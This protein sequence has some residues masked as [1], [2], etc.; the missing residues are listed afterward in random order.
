VA[1]VVFRQLQRPERMNRSL[2]FNEV[3]AARFRRRGVEGGHRI[4]GRQR[5]DPLRLSEIMRI[6]G[7][8]KRSNDRLEARFSLSIQPVT[9]LTLGREVAS[10]IIATHKSQYRKHLIRELPSN[11]RG[12]EP[13][14]VQSRLL[15]VA[16]RKRRQAFAV[17]VTCLSV[18]LVGDNYAG[19]API[20]GG[21]QRS[22]TVPVAFSRVV[23]D[24]KMQPIGPEPNVIIDPDGRG[25]VVGAENGS[26]G[27]A[28]YR[29]GKSPAVISTFA[30]SA[31]E[32][33]AQVA[34]FD[35]NKTP[36]IVV[37]GSNG[38]TFILYNPL[39]GKCATVYQCPWR[40]GV[41]DDDRTH[42]SRD[43]VVGDIDRDGAVDI[44]T[45]A[46]VYFN[47]GRRGRWQFVGQ[48]LI[49]R[50]GDGTT[51]GDFTGNG[52]LDIVAPYRSGTVL[53]RFINPLHHGGDPKRDVWTEQ[54][55]DPHPLFYGNMTTA[56]ADINGDGRKDIV[57]APMHGG[58]G[59][60]WYEAPKNDTGPWRRHVI[61]PTINS[62]HQGS[63]QIGDFSGRGHADIAFAEQ[64]RSP[65][66]RV[67]IF[68]NVAG[69]GTQ[70]RL[71]V[72]SHKGAQ[73][74]EVGMLG[75]G[76][77]LSIVC[78]RAQSP[79]R[80]NELLAWEDSLARAA[81]MVTH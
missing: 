23:V 5:F 36:D 45:E 19:E 49:A 4:S 25:G 11:D 81:P 48:R 69:R 61:D 66:R 43:V 73:N 42:L 65:T 76:K 2:G 22:L 16:Q 12:L 58:G 13:D 6:A 14:A 24:D 56:V 47:S 21:I 79:G 60:V 17:V 1:G 70:W 18:L 72:L 62:V 30:R 44:V 64:G 52:I 28:L 78:V 57:L 53:A 3:L 51:L 38:I 55:I 46:G 63:L 32:E 31:G 26:A 74:I 50:D 34:D 15:G 80:N 33:D 68:Y 20:A 41:V 59:L 75:G 54:A 10:T 71:Q 27:F 7:R 35:G 39:H 77:R 67:G 8:F 29:P 40:R 37:G 9:W